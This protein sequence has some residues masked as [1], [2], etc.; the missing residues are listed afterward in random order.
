MGEDGAE[1]DLNG[2]VGDE[3]EDGCGVMAKLSAE[4]F[5]ALAVGA[6]DEVDGG[7]VGTWADTAADLGAP[8][9]EGDL[10]GERSQA[11]EDGFAP[12][13]EGFE[14][15]AHEVEHGD[16]FRS[17]RI[18]GGAGA[19]VSF[20]RGLQRGEHE[21]VAA[22]R[23]EERILL[24]GADAF[25]LAHDETG[26][27][28]P[29]Q[30]VAAEAH[31]IGAGLEAFV[32]LRFVIEGGETGEVDPG[33]AA[34]V[35]DQRKACRSEFRCALLGEAGE[36]GDGRGLDKPFHEEIA[37]M[38]A[39]DEGGVRG[40]GLGVVVEAGLVGGADFAQACAAGFEDFGD[41][42]AAADLDQFSAGD[43]DFLAWAGGEVAKDEDERS[44]AVVDD[45]GGGGTGGDG[46]GLLEVSGAWAAFAGIEVQF[47][48]GV[49]AGDRAEGGEGGS[50][51]WGAAEVGMGENAGAVDDGLEALA[52]GGGEDLIEISDERFEVGDGGCGAEGGEMM[53]EDMDNEGAGQIRGG[54]GVQEPVDGRDGALG[55]RQHGGW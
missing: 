45:G 44:S 54:D 41:A 53:A 11:G 21:L 31:Q 55:G 43:D 28:T 40:D 35:F 24:Q 32:G 8:F 13:V 33:T 15:N 50:G 27:R 49:T 52:G 4:G 1:I 9:A 36:V 5:D 17:W 46:D 34:E 16:C 12:A 26:L 22:E 48:I 47:E 39:Q 10:D 30:F 23:T 29:E 3:G 18:A 7:E 42:E 14:G 38:D 51:E 2:V 6:D 19:Q 25:G 20:D 37:A